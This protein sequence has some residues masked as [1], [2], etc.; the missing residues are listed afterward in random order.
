VN[1]NTSMEQVSAG[2]GK[3]GPGGRGSEGGERSS[4]SLAMAAATSAAPAPSRAAQSRSE[5]EVS[6]CCLCVGQSDEVEVFLVCLS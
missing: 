5:W 2:S 6:F 3:W 4:T 1:D